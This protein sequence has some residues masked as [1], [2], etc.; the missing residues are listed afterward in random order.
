[1]RLAAP[2]LTLLALSMQP[3]SAAWES[4]IL[5][6]GFA[7][8]SSLSDAAK[9]ASKEGKA[10]VVYYT[11]T[12]CPPCDALQGRLR[13]DAVG[14]PY[15][16]KYVFT[17]VWGSSMNASERDQY[18]TLYNVQGAPTWLFFNSDG[19]YMCTAHGGFESDEAGA[20]LHSAV[21][22]QL[23]QQRGA[24]SGPQECIVRTQ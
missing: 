24:T 10:V 2:S 20:K 17:A 11:R 14:T 8:E 5:P 13:K 15:R 1:M 7:H 9:R 19:E 3:A 12:R 21:Q 23:V 16:E 4:F 22:I 6:R 18:R